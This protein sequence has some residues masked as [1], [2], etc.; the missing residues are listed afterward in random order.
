MIIT[1]T[2]TNIN[3]AKKYVSA[4]KSLFNFARTHF[5]RVVPES[6][7]IINHQPRRRVVLKSFEINKPKDGPF[8]SQGEQQQK[9][10]YEDSVKIP[11]R[12]VG[13]LLSN[14]LK[15]RIIEQTIEA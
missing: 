1:Y 10:S 8:H 7:L 11:V 4:L 9:I 15:V 12:R 5:A 2:L 14:L 3:F 6:L 13:V